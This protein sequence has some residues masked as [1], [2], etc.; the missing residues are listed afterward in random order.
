MELLRQRRQQE[1][2]KELE[3]SQIMVIKAKQA[4][5]EAAAVAVAVAVAIPVAVPVAIAVAVAV[6]AAQRVG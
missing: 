2:N 6:A 1:F 3:D 5:G 4:I